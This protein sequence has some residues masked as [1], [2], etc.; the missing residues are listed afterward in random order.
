MAEIL[1]YTLQIALI[2]FMIG[3]LSDTGLKLDLADARAA[4]GDVRFLLSS[5]F[6]CFMAGPLL[7]IAVSHFLGL[8]EP[9]ALGLMLLGLTPCAPFLPVLSDVAKA[10]SAY[11]AAFIL[12]A[13]LGTIIVMPVATPFVAPDL[14]A[15]VGVVARPLL[16][17]VL[18]PFVVGIIVRQLSADFANRCDPIIRKLVAFSII[19]L[20]LSAIAQN[21]G[22]MLGAIGTRAIAAQLIYYA[23]LGAGS[24]ALSFG[25]PH[26]KRSVIALGVATRNVGAA[27]A[28]LS[29]IPGSDP[30]AS[31]MCILA[32]CITPFVGFAF[33]KLLSLSRSVRREPGPG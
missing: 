29:A 30:R 28:P 31:T 10:S 27:L 6:W 25:L 18:A 16:L 12:I 32:A 13:A 23:L 4:V 1:R 24:Y 2:S 14:H 19:V 7:A 17:L 20:F 26:E 9:Y 3:S 11:A 21:W 8:S 22:D 33:A 5:L 15:G